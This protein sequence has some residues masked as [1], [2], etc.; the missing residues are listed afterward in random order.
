MGDCLVHP[1]ITDRSTHNCFVSEASK[2]PERSTYW[3]DGIDQF[4]GLAELHKAFPEVIQWSFHQNLLLLVVIQQVIPKRL[5]R[6]CFRVPNNNYS[7]P[8]QQPTNKLKLTD[9]K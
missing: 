3:V 9:S 1:F 6:Q 4:P 5:F 2:S 7:I 8:V